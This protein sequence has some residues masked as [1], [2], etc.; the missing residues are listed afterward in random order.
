VKRDTTFHLF[1][2]PGNIGTTESAGDNNLDAQ[3]TG[4]QRALN[5]QAYCPAVCNTSFQLF[6]NASTDQD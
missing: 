3:G 1:V 6:S 5:R 4:L 2:S